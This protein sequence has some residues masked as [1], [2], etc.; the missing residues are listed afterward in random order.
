MTATTAIRSELAPRTRAAIAAAHALLAEESD[1]RPAVARWAADELRFVRRP[2]GK[3]VKARSTDAAVA[4]RRAVVWLV[5]ERALAAG[6]GPLPSRGVAYRLEGLG[7]PKTETAFERVKDDV[8]ALRDS[9]LLA[10]EAISDGSRD[11]LPHGRW[12]SAAAALA[13]LSESYERDLWEHA[14]VQAQVWIGKAGMAELLSGRARELGVDLFPA[15]GFSGAG[16]I[17][18]AVQNAARDPRPLVVLV[19][20]DRDSSGS[21]AVEALER[22]VRRD[23]AELGV[24]IAA[25]EQFAVTAEQVEELELPTQP[26][27]DSTHTR[28]GDPDEKVEL[29]AVP[30][31][32]LRDALTAA[33]DRWCPPELRAAALGVEEDDRA[34]IRAAKREAIGG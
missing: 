18:A 3:R 25:V 7:L 20:D 24:E 30:S 19:A 9:A 5:A 31:A 4:E 23:A 22:R 14:D 10:W 21:R 34:T 12:A 15:R 27:K 28:D 1:L 17:R 26:Q 6:D 13:W 11:V 16:F 8:L 2:G 32:A 29:D 33:V